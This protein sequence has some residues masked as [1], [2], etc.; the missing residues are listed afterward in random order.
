MPFE[1]AHSGRCSMQLRRTGDTD[2]DARV[3]V[4]ALKL[5]IEEGR[6]VGSGS[7]PL[8]GDTDRDVAADKGSAPGT[9][10][11]RGRDEDLEHL[12]PCRP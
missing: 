5:M 10:T 9:V 8:P 4:S 2:S 7:V 12:D 1:Y 6:K 3:S 11:V